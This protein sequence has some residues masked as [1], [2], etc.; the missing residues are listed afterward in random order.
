MP[1]VSHRVFGWEPVII[2]ESWGL[3]TVK[4]GNAYSIC[5]SLACSDCD[6]LFLD[7]RFSPSEMEKLY[8]D[9]RGDDYTSLRELYEPGY[10]LRNE[11]LNAGI[12]YMGQVESFLEPYLTFPLTVLDWGGDTGKNTPFKG[13]SDVFDIYDISSKPVIDGARIVSKEVA[14][15]N[16][17]KLIV[18]SNVLEHVSYPSDMIFEIKNAMD[19]GSILYI[20]VPLENVQINAGPDSYLKKK[21]WHEHINFFTETSLRRLAMNAGL[22]VVELRELVLQF[23]GKTLVMFQMA[24]RLQ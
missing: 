13:R 2:D 19:K 15:S 12:D 24:C 14:F 7:I 21:H 20:E 9:Y 17:Y 22:E 10:A 1:F 23:A 11:N 6:F 8:Q 4:T 3:Q 18:C 16:Q 5:K